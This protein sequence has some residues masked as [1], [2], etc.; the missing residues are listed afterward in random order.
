MKNHPG[1]GGEQLIGACW[2]ILKAE[3]ALQLKAVNDLF[4]YAGN[5]AEM[6]EYLNS[7]AIT[8]V[9][10]EVLP[11]GWRADAQINHLASQ[12]GVPQ[13]AA[14]PW[15]Q[16][17]CEVVEALPF[18]MLITDMRV[19]GLPITY[20]NAA[21]VKLTGYDK[22]EIYGRNCRFLQ[23]P[24]TEAAAVREMVVA[25]RTASMTETCMPSARAMAPLRSASV[26][27]P[28]S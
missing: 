2:L 18:A 19:P 25:I 24:R 15:L 22:G 9:P 11:D 5:R 14:G 8:G 13:P 4:L 21:T 26:M 16:M 1:V 7:T 27:A 12:T 20:C 23:G 10:S 3:G 6:L 28:I 17:L